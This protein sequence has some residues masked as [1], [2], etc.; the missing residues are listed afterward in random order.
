VSAIDCDVPVFYRH[1][2]PVAAK[3]HKCCECRA[4]I[5]KGEKHF[6]CVGKWEGPPE[7]FRQH[8]LCM[9]ACMLIR[10]NFGGDCIAFGGLKEEFHEIRTDGWY[11]ERDRYKPAWKRLRSLMAK[12]LWKERKFKA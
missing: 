2:E 3:E 8:L 9:E 1:S 4:P 12:I 6:M 10:D 11:P 7:R 5:L